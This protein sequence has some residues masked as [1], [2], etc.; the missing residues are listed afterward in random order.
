VGA[1]AS[2]NLCCFPTGR[3]KLISKTAKTS[4]ELRHTLNFSATKLGLMSLWN[5]ITCQDR[6]V[7]NCYFRK[8]ILPSQHNHTVRCIHH[9]HNLNECGT[10][11]CSG[12]ST[13]GPLISNQEL[14]M[15]HKEYYGPWNYFEDVVICVVTPC[16]DVMRLQIFG[17]TCYPL[18]F[19][20]M[21]MKA[22]RSSE[23]S[24]SYH[25]TTRSEDGDSKVFR[26]ICTLPHHYTMS[27][28]R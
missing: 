24:V 20:L 3:V 10:R 7:S 19:S 4:T 15:L 22:A 11:F 21:K 1:S 27:Q 6:T 14:Y 17:G 16:S 28:Y 26:N 13:H 12:F 25:I 2:Q 18:L 23:T 9:I 5:I 8:V